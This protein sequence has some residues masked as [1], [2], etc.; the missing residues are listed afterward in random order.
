M[1]ILDS[2]KAIFELKIISQN[3]FQHYLYSDESS[4]SSSLSDITD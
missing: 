3:S 2:N 4:A 1:V